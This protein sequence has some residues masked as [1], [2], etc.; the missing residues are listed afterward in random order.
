MCKSE[1]RAR[2]YDP[3]EKFRC[4]RIRWRSIPSQKCEY[5]SSTLHDREPCAVSVELAPHKACTRTIEFPIRNNGTPM[6]SSASLFAKCCISRICDCQLV[7]PCRLSLLL[8]AASR[9]VRPYPRWS[10]ANSVIPRAGYFAWIVSYRPMCSAKPCTKRTTARG[11]V[12]GYVR[13]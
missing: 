4:I 7:R 6:Y 10:N 11:N 13:V 2:N 1:E 12:A 9:A 5:E 8:C 3:R